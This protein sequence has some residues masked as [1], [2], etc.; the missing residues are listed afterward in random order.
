MWICILPKS[1]LYGWGGYVKNLTLGSDEYTLF[2]KWKIEHSLWSR[3]F[4]LTYWCFGQYPPD[5]SAL[6]IVE[7]TK[8]LIEL[9]CH[10][11]SNLCAWSPPTDV[12]IGN[13]LSDF[14][15]NGSDWTSSL[16]RLDFQHVTIELPE[17][18][19]ELTQ[20]LMQEHNRLVLTELRSSMIVFDLIFP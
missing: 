3:P 8:S 9:R 15:S 5:F 18:T 12:T 20:E 1:I 6:I 11:V 17:L 2:S 7:E 4:L 19:Q 10:G 16:A 14:R 13:L